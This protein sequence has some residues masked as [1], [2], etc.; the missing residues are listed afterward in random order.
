MASTLMYSV[1]A[2]ATMGS[3][4]LSEPLMK[5]PEEVSINVTDDESVGRSK[6]NGDTNPASADSAI[7]TIMSATVVFTLSASACKPL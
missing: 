2:A 7:I 5:V 1:K 6:N 4:G 3:G